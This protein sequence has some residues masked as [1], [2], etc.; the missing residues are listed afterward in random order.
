MVSGAR[1]QYKGSGSVNGQSG[2]GFLLTVSDGNLTGGGGTDKF[3]LKVT[4]ATGQVI[5]DNLVGADDQLDKG[6]GVAAG[7]ITIHKQ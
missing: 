3:R 1:A 5:Y 4:D 6:Q 2:Y 7:S